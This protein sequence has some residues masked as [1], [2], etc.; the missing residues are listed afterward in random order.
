MFNWF[1]K[2]FNKHESET[3]NNGQGKS[4]T[5]NLTNELLSL[6]QEYKNECEYLKE[7]K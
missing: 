4:G 7:T 5:F 1:K 6:A 2:F 3:T